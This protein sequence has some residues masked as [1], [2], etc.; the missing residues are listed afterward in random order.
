MEKALGTPFLVS[1]DGPE[2]RIW[3]GDFE[4][5]EERGEKLA[6]LPSSVPTDRMKEAQRQ[7]I[8]LGDGGGTAGLSSR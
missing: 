7:A 3:L 5:R 1:G 2:F 6:Y 8:H 4:E